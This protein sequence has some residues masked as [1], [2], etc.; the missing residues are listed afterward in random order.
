MGAE[1]KMGDAAAAMLK[2]AGGVVTDDLM[3]ANGIKH[4]STAIRQLRDRGMTVDRIMGLG[5][6]LRNQGQ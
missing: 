2:S 5:W 1:V 3:R 6:R 4:P